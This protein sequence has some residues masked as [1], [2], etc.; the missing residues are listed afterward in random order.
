[1]TP[2]ESSV[3]VMSGFAKL[4]AI[5]EDPMRSFALHQKSC[6]TGQMSTK[7]YSISWKNKLTVIAR[8]RPAA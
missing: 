1:M 3:S 8:E 2:L 7:I 5:M 6:P 4:L